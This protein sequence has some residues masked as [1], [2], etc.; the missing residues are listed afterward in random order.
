ML[1]LFP[2][3]RIAVLV[4]F[5]LLIAA[6]IAYY[7]YQSRKERQAARPKNPIDPHSVFARQHAMSKE[8]RNIDEAMARDWID[9]NTLETGSAIVIETSNSRYLLIVV[10]PAKRLVSIMGIDK[11]TAFPD[12]VLVVL[13]GSSLTGTGSLTNTGRISTDFCTVLGIP[14]KMEPTILSPTKKIFVLSQEP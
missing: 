7:V 14:G 1:A 13:I 4:F 5:V 9:C 10:D 6:I 12:P 8:L 11:Q 2:T 3:L